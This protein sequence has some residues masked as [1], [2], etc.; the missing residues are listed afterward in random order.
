MPPAMAVAM[1]N[2]TRLF[3]I[4]ASNSVVV[5]VNASRLKRHSW[6]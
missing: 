6:G 2:N 4:L 3:F 5:P 1:A